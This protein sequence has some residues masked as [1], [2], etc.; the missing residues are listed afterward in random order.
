MCVCEYVCEYVCVCVCDFFERFHLLER[1]RVKGKTEKG[2]Q[3]GLWGRNALTPPPL[4]G[5]ESQPSTHDD[6]GGVDGGSA[7]TDNPFVNCEGVFSHA[8]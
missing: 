2:T 3:R 4:Y 8:F 5:K 7:L 6:G 1:R